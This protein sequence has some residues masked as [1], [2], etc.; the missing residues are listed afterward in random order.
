[1]EKEQRHRR[2]FASELDRKLRGDQR[3]GAA[4]AQLI[5]R[6]AASTGLLDTCAPE[7]EKL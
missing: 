5:E 6:A 2:V 1:M 7:I 3:I 4:S